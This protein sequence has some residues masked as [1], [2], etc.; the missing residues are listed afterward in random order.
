MILEAQI[1]QLQHTVRLWQL[2]EVVNP[3]VILSL[4]SSVTYIYVYIY[5]YVRIL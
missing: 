3:L 5:I 2:M 1:M 4:L